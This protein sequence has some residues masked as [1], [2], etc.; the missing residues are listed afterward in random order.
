MAINHKW[1][2]LFSCFAVKWNASVY[3]NLFVIQFFCVLKSVHQAVTL[4]KC[5]YGKKRF[6]CELSRSNSAWST[7]HS[8]NLMKCET[9]SLTNTPFNAEKNAWNEFVHRNRSG[10]MRKLE[11]MINSR[12]CSNTFIFSIDKSRMLSK[13]TW[14]SWNIVLVSVYVR[15]AKATR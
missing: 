1:L 6:T 4:N 11:I 3:W 8:I 7:W 10:K 12:G 2:E 5:K 14:G 9:I 13:Y 15:K